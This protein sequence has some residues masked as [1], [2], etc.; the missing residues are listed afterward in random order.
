MHTKDA[1][2]T[3]KLTLTTPIEKMEI[4]YELLVEFDNM[5]DNK[6]DLLHAIKFQ[7]WKNYFNRL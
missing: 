2:D 4:L 5:K 1:Y 6:I 7:G 3:P